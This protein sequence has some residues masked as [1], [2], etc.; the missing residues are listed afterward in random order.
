MHVSIALLYIS[1][2]AAPECTSLPTT[3]DSIRISISSIINIAQITLVHIDKLKTTVS[4][5]IEVHAPS[6]EG[7]TGISRDLGHL[8]S[9]LRSP[10]TDLLDQVVVDVSSLDGRVRS[11]AA[12]MN[13]TTHARPTATA[14]DGPF[15]HSRLYL[16]LVKL[17]HYLESLVQ[18]K[19]KL[20]IC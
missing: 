17:Q 9:D 15:P 13:C 10:F 14:A 8:E 16:T 19:D 4:A 1:L 20:K 11:L 3:E 7:L 2:M 5:Q 6:I 18:N 12:T